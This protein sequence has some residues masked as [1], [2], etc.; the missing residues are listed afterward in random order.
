VSHIELQVRDREKIVEIW[1]TSA[2]KKD[3]Q[4]Q[5]MLQPVYANYKVRKYKVAV[6]CSGQRDLL[7]STA[8]L[9]LHNRTG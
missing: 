4:M 7:D 3:K 9:L 2:E 8:G 6:F 5:E 1:L